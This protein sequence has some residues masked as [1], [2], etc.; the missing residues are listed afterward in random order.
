MNQM[1]EVCVYCCFN[2]YN[3]LAGEWRR[4]HDT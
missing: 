3:K 2:H 1:Q 4:K